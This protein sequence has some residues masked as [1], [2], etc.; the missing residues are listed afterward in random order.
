[1]GSTEIQK[2][3]LVYSS[4]ELYGS[5]NERITSNQFTFTVRSSL[6]TDEAVQSANEYS[7]L[8]TAIS[9][10]NTATTNAN[11][12]ASEVSQL[13]SDVVDYNSVS[14]VNNVFTLNL[15][16]SQTKN[17]AIETEDGNA[18]T[19]AFTNIPSGMVV[20]A[21]KLKF[22][23]NA[24]ITY[25]AEVIWQ[26]ANIPTFSVGKTYILSFVNFGDGHWL[27]ISSGEWTV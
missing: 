23:N 6:D 18:K 11:N 20:V 27:G 22:T 25:P 2:T 17:F 24:A 13:I 3:G 5:S 26:N 10:A 15:A 21:I 19:I 12:A 14:A 4:V 1:L 16:S 9:N 7:A 8:S